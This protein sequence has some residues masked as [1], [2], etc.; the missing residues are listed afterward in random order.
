MTPAEH[1]Q[2]SDR[3]K[4]IIRK[5]QDLLKLPLNL[6]QKLQ[7]LESVKV[8]EEELRQHRLNYYTLTAEPGANA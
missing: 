2:E 7:V 5:T 4:L 8:L 1:E 6:K 3:I